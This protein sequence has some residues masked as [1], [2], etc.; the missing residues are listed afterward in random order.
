MS[1]S[2]FGLFKVNQYVLLKYLFMVIISP[3]HKVYI[4]ENKG[5][6]MIY[7]SECIK[8]INAVRVLTKKKVVD[9]FCL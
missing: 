7:D 9:T 8:Q 1:I 2:V 5:V 3:M 4:Y 6:P